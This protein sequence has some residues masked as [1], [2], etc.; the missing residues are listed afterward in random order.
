LRNS[1]CNSRPPRAQGR[2]KDGLSDAADQ[3]AGVQVGNW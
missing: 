1:P 2:A 3:M